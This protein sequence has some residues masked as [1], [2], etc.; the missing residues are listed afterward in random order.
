MAAEQ[1]AA[2][3]LGWPLGYGTDILVHLD[4]L[5]PSRFYPPAAREARTP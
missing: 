5:T 1:L 4:T 2:A 3:D